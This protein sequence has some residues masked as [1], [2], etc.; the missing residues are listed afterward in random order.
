MKTSLS[1]N[2][3]IRVWWPGAEAPALWPYGVKPW[4]SAAQAKSCTLC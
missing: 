4:R 3:Q 1:R 2:D